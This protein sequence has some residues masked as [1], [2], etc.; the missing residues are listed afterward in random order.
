[1]VI[2]LSGNS[3]ASR[4]GS[5]IQPWTR[6]FQRDI[7]PSAFCT[8]S[9][10][11]TLQPESS[12]I[13]PRLSPCLRKRR[14]SSCAICLRGWSFKLFAMPDSRFMHNPIQ[15]QTIATETHGS[16]RT[17]KQLQKERRE[18]FIGDRLV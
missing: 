13:A 6:S 15:E 8:A 14:R 2:R 3:G 1:M 10:S 17:Q 12:A 16:T 11:V 9:P 5:K 7:A 4:L 18:L